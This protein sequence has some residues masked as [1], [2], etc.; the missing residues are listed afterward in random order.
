MNRG[1]Q[2]VVVGASAGG[3]EALSTLVTALPAGFGLPVVIV[4][5][6]P[7]DADNY[8]VEH[9][10]ELGTLPVV[11]AAE[12]Q[13]LHRGVVYLAPAGYHLLIET[14]NGFR[15]SCENPVNYSQPSIDV[16]FESASDVYAER[17]IG[18]VLTGSNQDGAA[19]LARIK[20][21]GGLTIV[22]DPA[23]AHAGERHPGNRGG[24]RP[25][26]RGNRAVTGGARRRHLTAR[27]YRE[28]VDGRLSQ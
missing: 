11:D 12:M 21:R 16:L 15:L 7:R 22:Q 24:P 17:L 2:A 26:R 5:H 23:S 27:A 3:L 9:L 19:G 25:P 13:T 1:Y 28:L 14:G 4:Q 10:L 20:D 18:V 6:R 8:L